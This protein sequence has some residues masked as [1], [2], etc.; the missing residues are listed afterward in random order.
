[1]NNPIDIES[2][3]VIVIGSSHH[4][5]LGVIRSLGE[6]GLRPFLVLRGSGDKGGI[7]K[8]RYIAK[9]WQCGTDAECLEC[10]L[11]NFPSETQK[12]VLI[13]TT[14]PSTQLL[15]RCRTE[16][17]DKFY[18]PICNGQYG[19]TTLMD[20]SVIFRLAADCGIDVPRSWIV[21]GR[22]IDPK[23]EYPCFAKPLS[24]LTGHKSDICV[25]KD[26]E[27]L[28]HLVT[29]SEHCEDYLVQEKIDAEREISIL[30]MV[31]YDRR[32]IVFSGCI[33]K[34]RTAGFG[35]STFAVMLDNSFF[36]AEMDK[37]ERL[38]KLTGY[39]GL[40]SAEYLQCRG[41]YYFLEVNFRN[42]G[43]G[44]VPTAAGLNLPYLWYRSCVEGSDGN[45][46]VSAP[47]YPCYF[48]SD[49]GDFMDNVHKGK[50]SFGAW[51][52]DRRQAD[53]FLLYNKADNAPFWFNVRELVKAKARKLLGFTPPYQLVD[54]EDFLPY[55][56]VVVIGGNH[57]NTLGVL[58]A[59]GRAGIMPHL[60]LTAKVGNPFV[61]KSRYIKTL[62][63]LSN[64]DDILPALREYAPSHSLKP[65]VIACH[66]IASS[67]LDMNRD[68]LQH[69]FLIP[70]SDEQGKLTRLMNKQTMGELAVECG[71]HVPQ[72]WVVDT[73]H[74][75]I[76]DITYSV[77]TKPL[78]SKIG[79]KADIVVC[80]SRQE[81]EHY[82]A[83]GH[84]EQLQVQ[85]FIKKRYEYQLI[86]CSLQHGAEVIIPGV[87]EL[88]RPGRGSNTGF[89]KYTV[90]DNTYTHLDQCRRFL[91][92]TGYSGLFSM[93]FLRDEEGNDW[94]MEINFRNDG[95]GISVTNAGVNLPLIW[96]QALA[97]LP[98]KAESRKPIHDEYVMPNFA[99]YGLLATRQMTLRKLVNDSRL[100]TSSMD[101][102]ADDPRPTHG[103]RDIRKA[104]ITAVA[105]YFIR[106]FVR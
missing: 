42:D 51:N 104:L 58:R 20:K 15:D 76:E 59:L 9:W 89:L 94:F 38:L 7:T 30:G 97:G 44:Y 34:L 87:S 72:T 80:N 99:E 28:R 13:S 1:M 29:S 81:L 53:C 64:H 83:Q 35:S 102:A 24:S 60:L 55:R 78:L 77:I 90:L 66:D 54:N 22:A 84:C 25:C 12:P 33:D 11:D 46:E 101:Y 86:G 48:M 70:C 96:C 49:I 73:A 39:T 68:E 17:E 65:I 69:D 3:K 103:R 36:R 85:R 105:K 16:L 52:K 14:D 91:K 5:T 32:H 43:N 93:E 10:L 26:A 75:D 57:H 47:S 56:E 92:A 23:I 27:A 41:K 71:L 2:N 61:A 88:I 74:P 67:I 95:N 63:I 79:S 82:L 98:Y 100:A 8:S 4:N 40:F 19:T 45:Q 62:R 21:R 31:S 50:M 18:L 37:L 6:K 106:T